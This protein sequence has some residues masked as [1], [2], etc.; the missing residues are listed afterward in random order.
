MCVLNLDVYTPE[1]TNGKRHPP[2][3]MDPEM[4]SGDFQPLVVG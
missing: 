1:S 2:E 3:V 4:K